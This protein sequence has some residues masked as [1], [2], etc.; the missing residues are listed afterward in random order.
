MNADENILQLPCVVLKSRQLLPQDS[1]IYYVVDEK[2]IVWYVG[3]T[4]KL[5]TRWTGKNHHR[6]YQLQKQKKKLFSIYYE[7]VPESQLDTLEQKRI[8]QYNPLLNRTKVKDKKLHLTETLL[9]ETLHTIAP[10]CFVLG[11]EPPR[12]LDPKLIEDS[13]SWRD[14]WRVQKTVLPLNIIHICINMQELKEVFNDSMQAFRFVRNLFKK[15]L[16]YSD[17]WACKGDK[18]TEKATGIVFLRRLLVNGFAIE[19]YEVRPEALP[20][21]QG[22]NNV[23][24]AGINIRA[25]NEVSLDNLKNQCYVRLWGLSK[26]DKSEDSSYQRF[27]SRTLERLS[28]YTK[29]LIQILFNENL[30]LNKLQVSTI[31]SKTLE[32]KQA[33]EPVNTNLPVRL[34]NVLAKK[35]YLKALLIERGINLDC[36]QVNKYL[37]LI[38]KDENFTDSNIYKRMTIYVKSFTYRDLREPGYCCSR[39]I[40]GKGVHLQGKNLVDFPYKEVYLAATV[41]RIFWLL[42]E[43]YLSDFAKVRLSEHEGYLAKYY[44]SAR[45]VLAPAMLTVTLNGKWKTDIPFGPPDKISSY[46]EVVEIIKSRLQ[47]SGIPKLRCSFKLT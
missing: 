12:K 41:D 15:R 6:F 9:R 24:L 18:E 46:L 28:P 39:I 32:K 29:D 44:I 14:N 45:K 7:L 31:V 21:I 30:N 17:N 2:S 42:L 5:R 8:E 35:E 13:I 36:Y 27:F 34:A 25:V 20:Y 33:K 26:F 10:Y 22:Y 16:N 37:Q 38:P 4:K 11:E 43:P 3:K 19:I 1:A 23:Q 40:G 47:Q